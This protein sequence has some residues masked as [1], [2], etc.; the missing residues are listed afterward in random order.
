M[1]K[2]V[3]NT[4]YGGFELS[5]AA[6]KELGVNPYNASHLRED[7]ALIRLIQE[8]GSEY[9]SGECAKLKIVE[10]PNHITRYEIDDR[11]GKE[12]LRYLGE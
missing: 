7:K 8:K 11:D 3:I 12:T 2:I 9:V 10:I 6:A 4:C 1:K 5:D